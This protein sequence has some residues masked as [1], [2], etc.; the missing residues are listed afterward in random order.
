[1]TQARNQYPRQVVTTERITDTSEEYQ[2]ITTVNNESEEKAVKAAIDYMNAFNEA[3]IVKTDS[4]IHYPHGLI[5]ANG[6]LTL[7]EKAGTYKPSNFFADFRQQYGWNH[8]CWDSRIVI[9]SND[10]KVHLAVTY[11]R[12]RAD[13]SKIG[14]F[15]SI[16]IMTRQD[17]QWGFKLRSNFDR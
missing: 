1:M 7:S 8:S 15:P 2:V 6:T 14:T 11:S 13:G 9:Q 10:N 16:W 4:F 12:Y 5:S 3:D 17:N